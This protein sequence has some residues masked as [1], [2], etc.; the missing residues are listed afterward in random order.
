M[1]LS[2]ILQ[3]L[4]KEIQT[5]LG[6]WSG[7]HGYWNNA[8]ECLRIK[9][10]LKQI[11][12]NSEQKIMPQNTVKVYYKYWHDIAREHW[13]EA[14]QIFI[15]QDEGDTL[16]PSTWSVA[17]Q[18]DGTLEGDTVNLGLFWELEE[19]LTYAT[20]KNLQMQDIL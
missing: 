9:L 8:P 15:C 6:A 16:G 17:I 3:K 13:P 14:G 7:E 11:A 18:G 10:Y 5:T 1:D 4:E 2:N 12:E 19:A 20:A